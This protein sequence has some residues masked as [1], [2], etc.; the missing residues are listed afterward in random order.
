MLDSPNLYEYVYYKYNLSRKLAFKVNTCTYQTHLFAHAYIG[1]RFD[2]TF[3]NGPIPA[4]FRL[5]SVFS[6][7]QYNFL[8]QINVKKC[9]VHQVNGSGIQTHDLPNI[10][11]LPLPLD[12]PNIG[13]LPLPLDQGSHP[14]ALFV[15]HRTQITLNRKFVELYTTLCIWP[16]TFTTEAGNKPT[17]DILLI[18]TIFHQVWYIDAI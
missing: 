14:K 1:H 6:N 2:S 5:F 11:L 17:T 13:L 9:H 12:L 15:N 18:I 7:K 10:G 8:Q 3:L 4:F 16:S